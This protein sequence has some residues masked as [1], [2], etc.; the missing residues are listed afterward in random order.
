MPSCPLVVNDGSIPDLNP[1]DVTALGN[2]RCPRIPVEGRKHRIAGIGYVA[3]VGLRMNRKT[4]ATAAIQCDV[5]PA[6]VGI[7][8]LKRNDDDVAVSS[9][10]RL[11]AAKIP[12]V[13]TGIPQLKLDHR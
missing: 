13:A 5:D 12:K 10:D 4:H 2:P 9:C 3:V 7:P 6:E 8:G 1:Y 11:T